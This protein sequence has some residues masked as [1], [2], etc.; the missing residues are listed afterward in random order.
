M[1][2]I[3]F[4]IVTIIIAL[5][6]YIN[7][8]ADEIVIPSS[9]IRFRVVA[10]SNSFR[11]Q[12]IKMMV[13]EYIDDYLALKMVG[14]EDVSMARN[15][16]ESELDNINVGIENLFDE[17]NYNVDFVIH[18][19][20][21]F[22]P[23]KLYNGVRYDSGSSESLVVSIGEGSGDNWWWVLFPPLCLLEAEESEFDEVEYRFF[24]KSLIDKIFE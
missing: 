16:I 1:R 8:N 14:V 4:I 7:V 18:Y 5:L 21:V 19:G 22:F 20:E 24:V 3:L 11:D 6:V 10:N 13:R 23:D 15:I 2:K 9:A 12:S 17:N